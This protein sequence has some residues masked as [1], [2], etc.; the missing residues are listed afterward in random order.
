VATTVGDGSGFFYAQRVTNDDT[1]VAH[2]AVSRVKDIRDARAFDYSQDSVGPIPRGGIVLVHH[3]ASGR[4]LALV[5]DA[6]RPATLQAD[7]IAPYAYADVTW[8]LTA[9]GS[10]DFSAAP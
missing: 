9:P 4:Y 10:A 1:R 3:P 8:Y 2:A 5:L 6:I 7:P